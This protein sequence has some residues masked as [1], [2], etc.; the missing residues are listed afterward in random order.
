MFIVGLFKSRRRPEVENA[1][2]HQ[3]TSV[4]TENVILLELM[5]KSRNV[6]PL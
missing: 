5:T 1:F 2:L 4:R 3:P 6:S